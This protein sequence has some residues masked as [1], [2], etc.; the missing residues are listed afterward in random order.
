MLALSKKPVGES[1]F[2]PTTSPGDGG[3]T[4][5]PGL[6]NA[7]AHPNLSGSSRNS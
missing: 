1:R 5:A 6:I 2:P 3:H 7:V 4:G